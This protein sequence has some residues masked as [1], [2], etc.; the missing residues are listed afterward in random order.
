MCCL[1]WNG[2]IQIRSWKIRSSFQLHTWHKVELDLGRKTRQDKRIRKLKWFGLGVLLQSL[3]SRGGAV[4]LAGGP[5]AAGTDRE[6]VSLWRM[7]IRQIATDVQESQLR[8]W[9]PLGELLPD[10][11]KQFSYGEKQLKKLI[12]IWH[13]SERL[14]IIYIF[15]NQ[16]YFFLF[17]ND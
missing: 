12:C 9:T 15:S 11:C 14:C 13:V 1:R 10:D 7:R 2:K 4:F 17:K 3:F 5:G 6:G 16:I 8:P